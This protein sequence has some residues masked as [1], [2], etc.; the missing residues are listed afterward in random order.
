MKLQCC[1][2]HKRTQFVNLCHSQC[3]RLE[4]WDLCQNYFQII[5][6]RL[7]PQI[8]LE[9]YIFQHFYLCD[10]KRNMFFP[11][12]LGDLEIEM[13][14]ILPHNINKIK[15]KIKSVPT[16]LMTHKP[17]QFCDSLTNVRF[18]AFFFPHL[19]RVFY[20]YYYR[21]TAKLI[22]WG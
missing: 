15:E 18:R 14:Y 11:C 1:Q 8:F 10:W 9:V 16:L 7:H 5:S 6:Q 3:S 4:N 20:Y 19:L 12:L 2:N 13:L 17:T 21:I 22:Y